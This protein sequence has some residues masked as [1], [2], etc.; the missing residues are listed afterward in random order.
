MRFSTFVLFAST[1][2]SSLAA[3]APQNDA[4][5]DSLVSQANNTIVRLVNINSIAAQM[6][7]KSSTST[8]EIDAATRHVDNMLASLVPTHYGSDGLLGGL[9][10]GLGGDC[11]LGQLLGGNGGI[12]DGLLSGS[13]L[14]GLLGSNNLLGGLL[15]GLVGPLLGDGGL[16][17]GLFGGGLLGGI[18]GGGNGGLAGSIAGLLDLIPGLSSSCGTD[19][20]GQLLSEVQGLVGQLTDILPGA[21]QC[22]CGHSYILKNS[23]AELI[24]ANMGKLGPIHS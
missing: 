11:G 15:G 22:A 6:A 17:G 20:V 3:P 16:L 19:L 1:F 4:S 13:V 23:L 7:A 24:K 5:V 14:G 18:L 10:G 12:L 8:P 21:Q 2:A 9:L